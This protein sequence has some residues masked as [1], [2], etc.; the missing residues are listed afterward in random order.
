MTRKKVKFVLISDDMARKAT[1]KKKKKD[2]IKKV[3]ELIIL[4]GI[5]AC[6]ITSSPSDPRPKVWP[7]LE[8]AKQMIQ[9]YLNAFV[10]DENKNVNQESFIMQRIAKAHAQLKKLH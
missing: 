6:V 7:N 1:Y 8:A 10:L 3:N 2:L 4:Y 5:P 9:R